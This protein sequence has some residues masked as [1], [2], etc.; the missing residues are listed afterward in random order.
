MQAAGVKNGDRVLA[1]GDYK[2]TNWSDLTEAG[3][4][5]TKNISKGDTISVKVKDKSGR[6]K[7]L[8]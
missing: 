1:I 7:H 4:K 2:V 6:L 5:S 3:A 8:L